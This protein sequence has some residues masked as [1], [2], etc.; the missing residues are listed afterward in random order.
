MKRLIALALLAAFA[1]AGC[2]EKPQTVLY[3]DGKYRGKPDTRPWDNTPSA[4]GSPEWRAG[5]RQTWDNRI[6]DRGA[7]QNEYS[8]IGH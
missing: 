6:R 3:K 1:A 5:D 4:Y 2:S 8:R 7:T